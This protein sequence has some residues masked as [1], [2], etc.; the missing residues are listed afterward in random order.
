VTDISDLIR[1]KSSVRAERLA[2]RRDMTPAVRDRHDAAVR[3]AAVALVRARRPRVA[4]AYV[5]MRGEPGG[6][7]LPAAL[8][9]ARPG[10]TLLLPVVL[11]DLD[12]D[13]V[14]Y[15]GDGSLRPAARGLR[16][17]TGPRLGPDAVRAADLVIV[18]ALAVDRGGVR[19]GR[20]GGS[21]DRS[22]A[23]VAGT[24]AVVALLYPGELV[25]RLPAGPH[26]RAV[27]AVVRPD[28]LYPL[29]PEWTNRPAMTEY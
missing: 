3:D 16:E 1:I 5:P 22:L 28:G 17:P 19:L 29:D 13:W 9:G 7:A 25:E 2:A 26:D 14:A 8:A 4:A 27:S 20:G 18:P 21:Y 11:P 12:L 15:T 24:T 6:P 23:R 10:L